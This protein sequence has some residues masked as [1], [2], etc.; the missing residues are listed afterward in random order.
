MRA[1]T[2]YSLKDTKLNEIASVSKRNRTQRMKF[3]ELPIMLNLAA[4]DSVYA[5]IAQPRVPHAGGLSNY[6]CLRDLH[7]ERLP[8]LLKIPIFKIN[9]SHWT[10]LENRLMFNAG[11][12]FGLLRDGPHRHSHSPLSSPLHSSYSCCSCGWCDC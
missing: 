12:V 6:F 5:Q 1:D 10:P 3:E 8:V 11:P 4:L 7:V 2:L 9:A